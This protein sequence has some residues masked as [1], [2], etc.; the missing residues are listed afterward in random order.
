MNTTQTSRKK[1]MWKTKGR[2]VG[3]HERGRL[4][5][6]LDT[7]VPGTLEEGAYKKKQRR[8]RKRRSGKGR[9][10]QLLAGFPSGHG[11]GMTIGRDLSEE[12]SLR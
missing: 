7:Q 11:K 2:N 9:H 4:S 3:S 1:R 6:M 8:E 5:L 12:D 10:Q